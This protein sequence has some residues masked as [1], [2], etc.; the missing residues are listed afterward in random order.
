MA[1]FANAETDQLFEVKGLDILDKEKVKYLAEKVA[2]A[3]ISEDN[4]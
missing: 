2:T 3:A 4:Y 1:G